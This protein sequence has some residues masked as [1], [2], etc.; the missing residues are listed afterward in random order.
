MTK[1]LAFSEEIGGLYELLPG[2]VTDLLGKASVIR[3]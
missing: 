2:L 1:F 3:W